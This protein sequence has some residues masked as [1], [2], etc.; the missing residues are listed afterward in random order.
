MSNDNIARDIER[1]CKT[2]SGLKI[3]NCKFYSI[4]IKCRGQ[5]SLTKY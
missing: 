3:K 5:L 1:F 2:I 4:K